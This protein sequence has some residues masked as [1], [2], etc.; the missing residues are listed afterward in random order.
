MKY[1]IETIK[2][3]YDSNEL[4]PG[5]FIFFWG[6]TVKEGIVTKTCF[7]QWYPSPFEVDGLRYETAEHWM[8]AGKAK[9]FNDT[10]TLNEIVQE[11]SPA[12]VKK[13]GRK[14]KNFDGNLW[15]QNA[16]SI[17]TEG[18]YHKFDQ[19]EALKNFL[20]STENKIIVE[21]SPY[22]AIWGTGMKAHEPNPYLWK[23]TNLLGFALM[24]A[25][26]MLTNVE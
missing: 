8:M 11:P 19:N 18:N 14:V 20:L 21:A 7:S 26:D 1:N 12:E 5:D 9:L 17:V 24:E 3:S 15:S 25:R 6:H 23:G 13:L 16:Y 10:A 22:D 2:K 4:R